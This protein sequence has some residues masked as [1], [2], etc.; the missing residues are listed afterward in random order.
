MN[1]L[2]CPSGGKNSLYKRFNDGGSYSMNPCLGDNLPGDGWGKNMYYAKPRK[3][4]ALNRPSNLMLLCE[5][6]YYC[7]YPYPMMSTRPYP[8]A[9]HGLDNRQTL[10]TDGHVEF[11]DKERY[12]Y[13]NL[14]SWGQDTLFK[15]GEWF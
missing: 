12:R 11:I 6:W 8:D 9:N 10:F 13:P 3:Y 2:S 15:N 5:Y 14:F 7:F 1:L 4:D